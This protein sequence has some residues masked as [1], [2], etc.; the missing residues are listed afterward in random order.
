[1]ADEWNRHEIVVDDDMVAFVEAPS[2]LKQFFTTVY[3]RPFF[4]LDVVLVFLRPGPSLCEKPQAVI[5]HK[6]AQHPKFDSPM[7]V[8]PV[9]Q[10]LLVTGF[11]FGTYQAF[12]DTDFLMRVVVMPEFLFAWST[13]GWYLSQGS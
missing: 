4:F 12:V 10:I 8:V 11:V 9:G 13:R 1:M 5:G 6:V 3:P 2:S 7:L